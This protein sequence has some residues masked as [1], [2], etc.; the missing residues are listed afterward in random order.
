M[1]VNISV[2]A[3][4]VVILACLASPPRIYGFSTTG[5]ANPEVADNNHDESLNKCMRRADTNNG[6][7]RVILFKM[8]KS[9][10]NSIPAPK[11]QKLFQFNKAKIEMDEG[12]FLAKLSGSKL[13]SVKSQ[14]RSVVSKYKIDDL[15]NTLQK[16]KE[17]SDCTISNRATDLLDLLFARWAIKE[18]SIDEVTH[19]LNM[20]C[21]RSNPTKDD[22][23]KMEV[24]HSYI[25]HLNPDEKSYPIL[26]GALENRYGQVSLGAILAR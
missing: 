25:K 17:S 23:R 26:L 7:E 21:R 12:K 18:K 6:E 15:A 9:F 4:A 5:A 8:F 14:L 1:R 3:A 16:A 11:L 24:L 20:F 19:F 10:V 22:Y 2:P 13:P